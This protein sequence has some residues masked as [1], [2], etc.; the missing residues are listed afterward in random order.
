MS[1]LVERLCAG[2][3]PI[4]PGLGPE[5]TAAALKEAIG[6]GYVRIRFND[7]VGGT[8]LGIELDAS[9]SDW[10]GA[11]LDHNQGRVRLAGELTLDYVKVRCIADIDLPNLTGRGRLELVD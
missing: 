9:R 2:D 4:E 11:D 1:S 8:E 10:Q 7:T 5:R 3:H 6:R